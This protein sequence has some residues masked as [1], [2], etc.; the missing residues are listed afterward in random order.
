MEISRW[1]SEGR[2][3]QPEHNDQWGAPRMGREDFTPCSWRTLRGASAFVNVIRWF[4]FADS[5]HHRLISFVPPGRGSGC[6]GIYFCV[7]CLSGDVTL[8]SRALWS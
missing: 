1:W 2:T 8:L 4:P 5:L 7:A 3:E 6:G